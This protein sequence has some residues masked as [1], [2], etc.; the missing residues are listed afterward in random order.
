[1][2]GHPPPLL[3][4]S[5]GAVEVMP[6]HGTLLGVFE[7]P[8]FEICELSLGPGDAI[9]I[10]SDGVLD[11]KID[12]V[13]LDEP[14]RRGAAVRGPRDASAQALVDRLMHAVRGNDRP[15]RDDVAILA[16]RRRPAGE[17]RA[18]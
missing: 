3:V 2:A 5:H 8:A 17:H 14:R 18:P 13:R 12:G 16:L 15:L 11:A 6:A 9:V 4:R 7:D 1:M 10:Y